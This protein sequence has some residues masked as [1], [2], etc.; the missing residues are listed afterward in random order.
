M[1]PGEGRSLDGGCDDRLLERAQG[2]DAT[3]FGVLVQ[4]HQQ[5]SLRLAYSIAGPEGEDAVQEAFVKAFL[6]LDR[7]R[8]GEPLRPWLLRIVANEARN[9]RRAAGRRHGLVLRLA[10]SASAD[11]TAASPEDA[12]VD[13]ERRVLLAAAVADLP[14]RDRA[15]IA[16][17]WFVGLSEAETALVL[18]CRPGTVKSRLSRATG[19]LR[20][21]L[22][23]EVRR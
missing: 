23:D 6:H 17:R 13:R 2:G 16:C 14:E 20:D 10:E 1:T 5:A 8:R 21:A 12:A 22:P 11:D 19:R 18:H 9:R 15:V 7:F 3:A 4:R